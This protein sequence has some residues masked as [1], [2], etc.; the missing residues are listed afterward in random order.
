MQNTLFDDIFLYRFSFSKNTLFTGQAI[1]FKK[2]VGDEIFGQ[3]F[4]KHL[5]LKRFV[6]PQKFK[7]KK[8]VKKNSTIGCR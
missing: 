2:N 7:N 1:F 8:I 5:L 4:K 6:G 3:K